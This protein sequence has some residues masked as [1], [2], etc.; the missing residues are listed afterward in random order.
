MKGNEVI[1]VKYQYKSAHGATITKTKTCL[2]AEEAERT[3]KAVENTTG[4]KIIDVT[5]EIRYGGGFFTPY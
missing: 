2:T 5:K 4:Y 3:C 1:N